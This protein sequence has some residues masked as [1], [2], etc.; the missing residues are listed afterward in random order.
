MSGLTRRKALGIAGALGAV[1]LLGAAG[2]ASAAAPVPVADSGAWCWFGGPR[3]LYHEERHRRTYLGYLTAAGEV[4][5]AQYDHDSGKLTK[6]V[7]MEH[8]PVDDHNNPAVCIRPDGRV[9]VFWTGHATNIPLLYRRSVLPEDIGGGWEP[10]RAITTNSEGPYGW[11]YTNLA[12]LSAEPG[13]LYLFWRG[14]DFN[15]YFTTTTGGDRWTDAQPLVF[16]PGE[17]PYVKMHSDGRD[18]IHFAFTQAHPRDV[19]TSIYYMY[20][21]GGNLYRADGGLI[22]PL[23]F[24]VNPSEAD[25]VYDADTGGNPKA[26]VWEIAADE[27]GRPVIVYANFPT[28]DDHRYHYAR[29]TGQRWEN[30]R[31]TAAGGTISGDP[32]EPNYSGG[33]SLDHEDPS[34]VLLSRQRPGQRHEVERWTTRNGGRTW[35]VEPITSNST[36]L[37]VRPFKPV[38]LRGNGPMSVLWMAGEYPSYTDFRTRIMALGEDGEPFA[39]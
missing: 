18:T 20:Y 31:I 6:S 8:F 39:L 23:G 36:E 13:K 11:T 17:R 14:G 33:V 1:P 35:S 29:W 38:G 24:P 32:G 25:K 3:A 21:R 34:V 15:P 26:W 2:T 27:R 4:V 7:V 19:H 16:V 30:H 10:L 12:Q 22:G 37:N 5:V 9:V 28:D